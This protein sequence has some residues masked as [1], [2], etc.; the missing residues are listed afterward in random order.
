MADSIYLFT[1]TNTSVKEIELTL[2]T[3]ELVLITPGTDMGTPEHNNVWHETEYTDGARLIHHSKKNR[4]WPM[5]LL[6]GTEASATSGDDLSNALTKLERLIDQARRY[7]MDDGIGVDRVGLYLRLEGS[8]SPTYFT[9]LDMEC[10]GMSLLD[11]ISRMRRD[12][13]ASFLLTTRPYG[14][15]VAET[16][17]NYLQTPHFQ[18]DVN[19][20]GLA[21]NWTESGA[22]TTTIDTDYFL[23]GSQSQKVVTDGAGTD[24][25]VSDTVDC[26]DHQEE[27]FAA[28]AWVYRASGDDITV[29]VVGDNSGSLGTATYDAATTEEEDADGNT[30]YRLEVEGTVGASDSTITLKA[31]RLTGDASEA[32]TF[33]VD[34]CYLQFNVDGIPTAWSSHYIVHQHS[35][36]EEGEVNYI[37]VVDVPGGA[38][39]LTKYTFVGGDNSITFIGRRSDRMSSAAGG[40]FFNAFGNL[41][42]ANR[43]GGYYQSAATTSS[44]TG[45]GSFSLGT[46]RHDGRTFHV[47]ASVYDPNAESA[48]DA[49]RADFR[50]KYG[51]VYS[52]EV[53]TPQ[54]TTAGYQWIDLGTISTKMNYGEEAITGLVGQLYLYHKRDSGNE[55]NR[56]D[57]MALFS[58]DEDASAMGVGYGYGSGV[59]LVM[60]SLSEANDDAFYFAWTSLGVLVPATQGIGTVP[61]LAPGRFQRLYFLFGDLAVNEADKF[62]STPVSYV[63]ITIYYIPRTGYFL[64][65]I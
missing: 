60:S 37:D 12:A 4:Q 33:Y 9:V 36:C 27:S 34:K 20:D 2:A 54:L 41:A 53:K 51:D 56:L 57:A 23:C 17:K 24:G 3:D 31:E 45:F 29:D 44:F 55:A 42:D 49:E 5:K 61:K 62:V 1:G 65:T 43:I 52:A 18:Q 50:L 6:I 14:Y 19:S 46:A 64:G 47:F 22:P 48:T 8:T 35:E 13:Q 16:L 15:G 32:T 40:T 28:Y 26:S 30:W 25:V 39:A 10:N 21:D 59:D 63:G 7:D 11:E 58:V 38:D